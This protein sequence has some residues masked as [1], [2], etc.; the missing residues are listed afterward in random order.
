M[1]V[2]YD[3]SSALRKQNPPEPAKVQKVSKFSPKHILEKN[4]L[5]KWE[6]TADI[7]C[8]CG[9]YK[10][11]HLEAKDICLDGLCI[12]EAFATDKEVEVVSPKVIA[13][14][15]LPERYSAHFNVGPPTS[16]TSLI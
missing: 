12:C 7:E 3:F 1:E 13:R 15:N 5:F 10:S 9:H 14:K 8:F 6:K 2:I 16:I 11:S 4:G